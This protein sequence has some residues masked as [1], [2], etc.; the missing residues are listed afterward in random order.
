MP[1]PPSASSRLGELLVESG[2]V[3]RSQLNQALARQDQDG[4]K[5]GRILVDMGL[6]REVDLLQA[7]SQQLNLPVEDLRQFQFRPHTVLRLPE[8][9][10]RRHRA[11]VLNDEGATIRVGMAD[12]TDIFAF[13][14]V[15][16]LLDKPI[17]PILVSESALHSAID[18][19]YRRTEEISNLAEELGQELSGR[20][21]NLD[22]LA[23]GQPA[24]DAPVIKLLQSMFDDA[25]QV[26]ASD[27]HIEPGDNL[28]RIRLR[29]DGHLQEQVIQGGRIAPALVTRLKLMAML[30]ISERRLPQDG[31]FTMRV[32]DQPIDVRLSTLPIQH[33]ESVVMRL[34]YQSSALLDMANL[35]IP[36]TM[37]QRV[38]RIIQRPAGMFLVTGPTGSGKNTTLYAALNE[39]NIPGRKIITVEDPVEYQLPRINQVQVREK[40]GLD[41][42]RTLRS[43]LRQ[44]PDVVMVGEMR[45]QETVQIGLRA[46]ITGHM[47][48]STLHTNSAPDTISRLMDMGA[49]GYM[50]AAAL[51]A[52]MAQRLV[53]R[54]CDNCA[55]TEPLNRHQRAW[56]RGHVA[57]HLLDSMQFQVGTGCAFCGN[58]GYRGRI[59]VYE[60]LELDDTLSEILRS[61]DTATFMQKARKARDYRP[62]LHCALDYAARGLTSVAEVMRLAGRLDDEG[63]NDEE[64]TQRFE[65]IRGGPG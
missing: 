25:V 28:L 16:R 6:L 63:G 4:L 31:R 40:I 38:K 41:F 23:Q 20:D 19:V 5:L 42:A 56:L 47:V 21:Y 27:I 24:Q 11:I 61:G 58:T 30:N 62:L 55:Q 36:D 22:D 52:V 35:G 9:Y 46:A 60:L 34:L 54:V 48:F 51:D 14:G 49:E 12:P 39:I 65:V 44:D 50:L 64:P 18:L 32:K 2:Y 26:G 17:E 29:V 8:A 1:A 33:G 15:Q 37:V 13:D 10:A 59:G 7:L 53:R 45:D 43:V 3:T 57:E